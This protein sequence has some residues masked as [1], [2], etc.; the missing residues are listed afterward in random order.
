MHHVYV[1]RRNGLRC[2]GPAIPPLAA[3]QDGC[4]PRGAGVMRQCLEW[5]KFPTSRMC[6]KLPS[7][8]GIRLRGLQT[9]VQCAPPMD[10]IAASQAVYGPLVSLISHDDGCVPLTLARPPADGPTCLR[11][12]RCGSST[13]CASLPQRRDRGPR[14][15]CCRPPQLLRENQAQARK[16]RGGGR[17][18][19]CARV[20]TPRC[21]RAS[22]DV[23][24][25]PRTRRQAVGDKNGRSCR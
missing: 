8:V 4:G 2:T 6:I 7:S 9:S 22:L 3:R 25:A 23:G 24:Q 21:S 5:H 12:D 18:L 20:C 13:G 1:P 17:G 11:S 15:Q 14:R 16:Q 10:C 19:V